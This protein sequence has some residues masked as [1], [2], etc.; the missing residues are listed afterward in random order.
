MTLSPDILAT[1]QHELQQSHANGDP[2]TLKTLATHLEQLAAIARGRAAEI[3]LFPD[4]LMIPPAPAPV[5]VVSP[6]PAP[7]PISSPTPSIPTPA[8]TPASADPSLVDLFGEW[9]PTADLS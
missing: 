6:A 3:E 1:I 2:D 8:P 7:G 5:T 9:D 4:G